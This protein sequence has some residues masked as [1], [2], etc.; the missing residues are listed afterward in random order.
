MAEIEA[1]STV[2]VTGMATSN[3]YVS[4]EDADIRDVTV[5]TTPVEVSVRA[6]GAPGAA[7]FTGSAGAAGP[8]GGYTGSQG[9]NG[10]TGSAGNQ[11]TPVANSGI[12]YDQANLSTIYNTTIDDSVSSVLVGGAQP[13][14][15]NIWKTKNLVQVIDA[16]LFP[17]LLPSYVVPTIALT[18]SLPAFAEVGS[19]VTQTLTAVV[20]D[21][22]AGACSNITFTRNNVTV[23]DF[24]NTP[25]VANIGVLPAQYGF[26]NDNDPVS[27]YTATASQTFTVVVGSSTQFWKATGAYDAGLPLRNNKG[28]YDVRTPAVRLTTAPQAASSR[29]S[30][31][32]TLAGVYPYFWGKSATTLTAS[33]VA[34]VITSGGANKVLSLMNASDTITVDYAATAEYIWLAH[35]QSTVTDRTT[36]YFNDLNQGA[37]EAS[38]N[39][40]PPVSQSVVSPD[41]Y[42]T[43]TYRIYLVA[44][45]TNTT[46]PLQWRV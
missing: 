26:A 41:G 7:G 32:I 14:T 11:F 28:V 16:I 38:S 36:W 34:N 6:V 44:L 12:L 46:E 27:T 10:F 29:D 42:W 40:L 31:T 20:T 13:A 45:P 25:T 1:V 35:A 19:N 18:D 8:A 23:F 4:A 9:L 33:D 2:Y 15:A 37:I 43:T 24:D 39:Y 22:D 3:V 17:D 30:A 5:T 21:N